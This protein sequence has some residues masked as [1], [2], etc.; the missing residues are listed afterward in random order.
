MTTRT[1]YSTAQIALHW[2]TAIGVLVAFFT[3]D[4][5]EEIAETTWEA[6]GAA[7]PTPHTIAGMTVFLLVLIRLVL[8]WRSGVPAPQGTGLQQTAAVWGHRLL[9]AMLTRGENY[10]EGGIAAFEA[11]REG[12]R[13]HA[14]RRNANQ[15]GFQLVQTD[16]KLTNQKSA[17]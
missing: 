6:G 15:L 1:G 4:A 3:H 16:P 13:L 11:E 12:R 17:A 14:L 5:M 2:L 9:Y 8:R 7:F 10:V